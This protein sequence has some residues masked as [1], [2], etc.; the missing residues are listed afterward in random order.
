M[1]S[2][3][4]FLKDQRIVLEE[5]NLPPVADREIWEQSDFIVICNPAAL[6]GYKLFVEG[7]PDVHGSSRIE[8]L[9]GDKVIATFTGSV[10]D[11]HEILCSVPEN[12]MR[13]SK[14][15]LEIARPAGT[16]GFS[17]FLHIEVVNS[18]RT[19]EKA[20][21]WL[22]RLG[23]P[24]RTLIKI[25]DIWIR[26]HRMDRRYPSGWM[27]EEL[28]RLPGHELNTFEF[29]QR[30]LLAIV[31]LHGRET[32]GQLL[33]RAQEVANRLRAFFPFMY[34]ESEYLP[35]G[36]RETE[37]RYDRYDHFFE[38]PS[39]TVDGVWRNLPAIATANQND[40]LTPPK[41]AEIIC[42]LSNIM[43]KFVHHGRADLYEEVMSPLLS[44][45]EDD[46]H[47]GISDRNPS[48]LIRKMHPTLYLHLRYRIPNHLILSQVDLMKSDSSF[49]QTSS[50]ARRHLEDFER[51]VDGFSKESV[52]L[53]MALEK[54]Q[55]EEAA[56]RG[57]LSQLLI[58]QARRRNA[59]D[60]LSE[61]FDLALAAQDK[62]VSPA[63]ESQDRNYAIQATAAAYRVH[64]RHVI[65]W[66]RVELILKVQLG[67]LRPY[68][69][70]GEMSIPVAAAAGVAHTSYSCLQL[71]VSCLSGERN[72][73]VPFLATWKD[74]IGPAKP[75]EQLGPLLGNILANR[76]A[77]ASNYAAA[78]AGPLLILFD[79]SIRDGDEGDTRIA[80]EVLTQGAEYFLDTIRNTKS[81]IH[82]LLALKFLLFSNGFSRSKAQ[83][84]NETFEA[85]VED[86]LS[87]SPR[88]VDSLVGDLEK[89][90]TAQHKIEPSQ[91]DGSEPGCSNKSLELGFSI[92]Y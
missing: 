7:E 10:T 91:P 78:L 8:E 26:I 66:D 11:A 42:C 40:H 38:D 13:I 33:G 72:W 74:T 17:Y 55:A 20:T 81:K 84:S 16:I 24:Q 69:K 44:L 37:N 18:P 83:G 46:L 48:E 49:R 92:P 79:Q 71:A 56:L 25:G 39:K 60:N 45:G 29:C 52:N 43:F 41:L 12:W 14:R 28:Y 59:P 27:L 89:M 21:T 62:A 80:K 4:R 67:T 9:A 75:L 63:Q 87:L 3:R 65:D 61:A 70:P 2:S 88:H 6:S 90:R 85:V 5:G 31:S 54:Y 73:E 86:L 35:K 47:F 22:Q 77:G 53:F 34:L 58:F 30:L 76:S 15:F 82:A 36:S 68:L 19:A 32:D 51:E 1:P 50:L 23:D 57:T 64:E